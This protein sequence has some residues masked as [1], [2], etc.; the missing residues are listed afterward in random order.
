[1]SKRKNHTRPSFSEKNKRCKEQNHT[2]PKKINNHILLYSI[3]NKQLT[4]VTSKD[5]FSPMVIEGNKKFRNVL[6][7]RTIFVS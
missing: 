1:M 4:I 7:L 2:F 5:F 6:I 3:F